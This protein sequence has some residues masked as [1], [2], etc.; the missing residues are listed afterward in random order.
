[1]LGRVIEVISGQPLDEFLAARVLGPLGMADTG[2]HAP[3]ADH[4]RLAALYVPR[5]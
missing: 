4:G 2:F 5:S 3:E 1:M